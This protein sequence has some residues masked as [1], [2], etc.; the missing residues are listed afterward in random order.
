MFVTVI[1]IDRNEDFLALIIA[2][3]PTENA[4]IHAQVVVVGG[5]G[6]QFPFNADG[7]NITVAA[8]YRDPRGVTLDHRIGALSKTRVT[9]GGL[10]GVVA[11]NVEPPF[12]IADQ[13]VA[14]RQVGIDPPGAVKTG[15]V[16]EWE[17]VKVSHGFWVSAV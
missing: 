11:Q 10:H 3:R 4:G 13:Q 7:A 8:G 12:N 5:T 2:V 6:E 14:A 15:V 17:G 1:G 9:L 16:A